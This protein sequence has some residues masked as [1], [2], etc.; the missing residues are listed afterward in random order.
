M[1]W[2]T[3]LLSAVA[4][5]C[6]ALSSHNA[7]ASSWGCEVLLCLASPHSPTEYA[8]CVAPITRLYNAIYKLHPDPFPTCDF[9]DGNDGSNHANQVMD[10][11]DPCPAGTTPAVKGTLVAEGTR[12]VG[13]PQ[14]PYLTINDYSISQLPA[15]SQ[16]IQCQY[17]GP[18][19]P[20]GY[21]EGPRACIGSVVGVYHVGTYNYGGYN[22]GGYNGGGEANYD[23]PV[24]DQVIWQE[25]QSP[26]AIDL[27]ID[28]KFQKRIHW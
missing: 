21:D 5:P 15:T 17:G 10:R 7:Q 2:Q 27:Y 1:K 16:P 26:R 8:E 4:L 6:L 22:G 24:Y 12:K 11:Y 19:Y 9:E 18:C 20:G 3:K 23:V 14:G 25:S 28:N 13:Q